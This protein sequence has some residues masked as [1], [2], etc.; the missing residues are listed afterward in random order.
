MINRYMLDNR[1]A[2]NRLALRAAIVAF[3]ICVILVSF[4]GAV[5]SY[6]ELYAN[7]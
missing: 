2:E 5:I 3:L 6:I 7:I 1:R 4:G